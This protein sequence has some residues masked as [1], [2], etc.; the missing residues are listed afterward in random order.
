MRPFLRHRAPSAG[1]ALVASLLLP[2][3][4]VTAAV[5]EPGDL[6]LAST[7]T[8]GTKGDQDSMQPSLSANGTVVA[9][10]SFATN[11]DPAD[12][13]DD[14]DVYVKELSTGGLTLA[15]TDAAGTKGS[16]SSANASLAGNASA[17]AFDSFATNLDP[18]DADTLPDAYVKDLTSGGLALASTSAAGEKGDG[19]SISPSLSGDGS[20]VA[21]SSASTNLVTDDTDATFDIFVKDLVTGAVTLASTDDVG[22]KGNGD[23]SE[24]SISADGTRVAFTSS[25][26][27]LDPADT[28]SDA[29]VYVKDLVS[30]DIVLASTPAVGDKGDG[31]DSS[32]SLSANG[33]SVAF[34]SFSTN[35]DAADSDLAEDVYVKDLDTGNVVLASTSDD[36]TKGD[37]GSGAPSL[38]GDGSKVAFQ[39]VASNLDPEHTAAGSDVYV[40]DLTTMDLALVSSPASFRPSLSANGASVAFEST[41]VILDPQDTDTIVDIYVRELGAA[42]IAA[43]LAVTV[44]D[45]PDPVASGQLLTYTVTVANHGGSDATGVTLVDAID[46]AKLR[47]V[48]PSQGSCVEDPRAGTVECSIGS[49]SNGATAGVEIVVRAVRPRNSPIVNTATVSG[50][51]PDPDLAN[52]EA[53]ETTTIGEG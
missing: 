24:A 35:L 9:F 5:A 31:A 48:T 7:S 19:S 25:S 4:L 36:G 15:S 2:F 40:K 26:T 13:V 45:S 28:E 6:V 42:P 14:G 41:S 22:N 38:S 46:D 8:D 39:S 10:D 23:S 17:V 49:L 50:N 53:M 12:V 20:L 34:S 27:N 47:S 32:P 51:E 29:D 37:A 30:G 16:F 21:F 43:D 52:N 11:L 18:A 3:L 44:V 1:L 33:S